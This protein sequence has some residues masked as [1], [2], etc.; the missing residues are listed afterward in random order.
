MWNCSLATPSKQCTLLTLLCLRPPFLLSSFLKHESYSISPDI[1]KR[2]SACCCKTVSQLEP[3]QVNAA[4]KVSRPR[5][6]TNSMGRGQRKCCV[7][8]TLKK[9]GIEECVWGGGDRDSRHM[10]LLYFPHYD[11]WFLH[12]AAA[13]A[14]FGE[15][16]Q[17]WHYWR[18]LTEITAWK[19]KE[20]GITVIS[21]L[22]WTLLKAR[23]IWRCTTRAHV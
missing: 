9:K 19:N 12:T 10:S 20:H 4:R 18:G 1:C 23:S 13:A 7:T 3:G 16:E 11:G 2:L 14:A 15:A 6:W 21:P 5:V 8:Q 17:T 22:C